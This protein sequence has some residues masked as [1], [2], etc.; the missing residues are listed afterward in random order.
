MEAYR[1]KTESVQRAYEGARSTRQKK[2]YEHRFSE[3]LEYIESS[4]GVTSD[5]LA[6]HFDIKKEQIYH[7]MNA[8]T[9]LPGTALYEDHDGKCIVYKVLRKEDL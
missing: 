4:G 8:L 9:L 6:K 1:I 5:E 3:I 2:R 7:I